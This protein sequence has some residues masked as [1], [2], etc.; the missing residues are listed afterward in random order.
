MQH[1]QFLKLVKELPTC[2]RGRLEGGLH[3]HC[4]NNQ[5][6]KVNQGCGERTGYQ[7]AH[8]VQ[9]DNKK[10][11]AS[12]KHERGFPALTRVPQ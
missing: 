10:T 1:V 12:M 4:A 11:N 6:A 5:M 7:L 9:S 3:P 2:T 8:A